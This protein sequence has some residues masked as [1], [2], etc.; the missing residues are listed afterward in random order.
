LVDIRN[1][2]E[3][4]DNNI[5]TKEEYDTIVSRLQPPRTVDNYLWNDIVDGYYKWCMNKYTET[6]SKGYKVCIMKFVRYITKIDDTEQAFATKFKPFT[7]QSASQFIESMFDDDLNSQ[8]IN[9]MKYALIVLTDYLKSIDIDA[10]DISNIKVSAKEERVKPVVALKDVEIYNIVSTCDLRSKVAI[11]LCYECALKRYELSKVK[12]S[13]FNFVNRQLFVY[14]NDETT[15]D[16]VCI[17]SSDTIKLVKEYIAQLYEDIERWNQSRIKKG[18]EP[19]EDFGYLF[20]SV[21]TAVPSYTMLQT[22]LKKCAK[23]YYGKSYSG[24]ELNARVGNFTFET[25]RNSRRVYLLAQGKTVQQVMTLVGDR[26]YMATYR[27]VKVVPMLYP[28]LV[29][30]E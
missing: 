13:D 30:V 6:T 3:M 19:R 20:Q 11:L 12:I 18:L 26:N 4:L 2:K 15:I 5:I 21:K 1:I 29:D 23:A 25:I 22:T 10:P 7:Y 16:R 28:E 9:K 8:T 27:F 17:L 14:D 24:E